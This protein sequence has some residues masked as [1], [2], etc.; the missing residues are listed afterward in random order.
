MPRYKVTAVGFFDGILRKPG[1]RSH[2]G[3]VTT[4]KALKPVPT[5]LSLMEEETAAQKKKRV[6]AEVKEAKNNAEKA[7]E[8]KVDIDAV[9]FIEPSPGADV[10]TL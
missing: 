9:T 5:W 1:G 8:D 10:E 3:V 7:L 6:A 4:D 2:R